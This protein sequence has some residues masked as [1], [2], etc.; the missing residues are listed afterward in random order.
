[1]SSHYGGPCARLPPP[2][3]VWEQL[4]PPWLDFL[5]RVAKI[6]FRRTLLQT[7]CAFW[8]AAKLLF[9]EVPLQAGHQGT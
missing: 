2:F 7:V 4:G 5:F 9:L 6:S 8:A 1:M 3:G